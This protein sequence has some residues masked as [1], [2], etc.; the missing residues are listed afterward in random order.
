MRTVIAL[1]LS[2]A[3]SGALADEADEAHRQAL[4]GRDSYWNCLA[5]EY[6][7]ERLKTMSS[8]D[9]IADIAA[10]CPSE[11]QN[12]RVMLMDY[13]A[14]EHPDQDQGARLTT[15]NRAIE[16]AQKDIV[17]A[18]VKRKGAAN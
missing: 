6:S 15:A 3:A 10:A 8:D 14:F 17:T 9:F 2:L 11:R 16:L 4:Q 13:L 7:Q 5:R 1:T 18:F 12:F